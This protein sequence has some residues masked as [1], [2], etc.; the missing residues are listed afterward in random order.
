MIQLSLAARNRGKFV[1][2]LKPGDGDGSNEWL[3][4]AAHALPANRVVLDETAK[5]L[6]NEGEV[7]GYAGWGSKDPTVNNECSGSKASWRDCD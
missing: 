4:E 1:I 2:D 7:I 6:Y 5:V 3:L